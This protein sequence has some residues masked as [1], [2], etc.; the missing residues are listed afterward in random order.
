[1]R[2]PHAGVVEPDDLDPEE[3]MEVAGPYL[4]EM[5]GEYGDWTPLRDR[6]PL[7]SLDIDADDPWQFKNFRVV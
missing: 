2:R 3:I 7:F 4:G 1:M 5:A 6:S